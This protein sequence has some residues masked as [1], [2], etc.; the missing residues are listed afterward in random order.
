MWCDVILANAASSAAVTI[1]RGSSVTEKQNSSVY[2]RLLLSF[3]SALSECELE[4]CLLKLHN[5]VSVRRVE[6]SEGCHTFQTV[7]DL[8]G[9]FVY[10]HT[11]CVC[12]C[13]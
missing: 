8:N 2:V 1:T 10:S 5:M 4:S 9:Q 11:L 7:L 13:V 6:V 12:I 3:L